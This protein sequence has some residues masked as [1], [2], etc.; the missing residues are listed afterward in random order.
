MNDK[1][2]SQ[3]AE[4]DSDHGDI[5]PSFGAGF[6]GFVITHQSALAHQPTEGSLHDPAARQY[7]EACGIVGAFDNL[8]GQFGA[9]TLDPLGECLAGVA[10]IDPQDAE[11]GEPAQ[12]P[13]QN[14]LRSVAF[15]GAGRS[16]GH[17]EQQ[18]QS[19]HQQMPLTTFDP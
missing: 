4:L 9:Q 8:D 19:I 11:P 16:H 12:Y 3:S 17:S 1:E 14:H 15:G 2:S 5:D 10:A 7:F 13:A 6:G 18:S